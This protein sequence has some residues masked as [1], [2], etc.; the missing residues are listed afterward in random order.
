[1]I[2]FPQVCLFLFLP[3]A[4][5]HILLLVAVTIESNES[6]RLNREDRHQAAANI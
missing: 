2:Y 3:F 5:L 4:F 6:V 1:M